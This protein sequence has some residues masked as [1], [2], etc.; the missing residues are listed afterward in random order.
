M[1][2][3]IQLLAFHRQQPVLGNFDTDSF[4]THEI[5]REKERER[6]V[7]GRERK[8]KERKV[9]EE[10]KEGEREEACVTSM[11]RMPKEERRL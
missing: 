9:R 1:K 5:R 3:Q 6:D 7:K 10:R 4:F 8:E 2:F 11:V